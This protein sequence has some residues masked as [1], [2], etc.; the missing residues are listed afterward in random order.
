MT[1]NSSTINFVTETVKHWSSRL[2]LKSAATKIFCKECQG[3]QRVT[4]Y[5]SGP[6]LAVL[7]CGHRRPLV[8]EKIVETFEK[9]KAALPKSRSTGWQSGSLVTVEEI[10]EQS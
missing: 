1:Y 5:F 2:A 8:E 6:K 10:G 3:L 4:D 9:A 7:E